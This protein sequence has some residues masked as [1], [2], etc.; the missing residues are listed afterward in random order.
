MPRPRFCEKCGKKL[1]KTAKTEDVIYDIFSGTPT[2]HV[3][4]RYMCVDYEEEFR[5]VSGK[6]GKL[7]GGESYLWDNGH[8]AEWDDQEEKHVKKG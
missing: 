5:W 8:T 3:S 4:E 6:S 1:F 7:S 2:V